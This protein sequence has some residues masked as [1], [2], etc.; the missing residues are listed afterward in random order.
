MQLNLFDTTTSEQ[1]E[2]RSLR[3]ELTEQNYKYY[4]LNAPDL[5]DQEFDAKMHR[6]QELE[7]LHPELF[8]PQSP[9]QQVGSD[10]QKSNGFKQ[11]P[12]RYPMLS[13]ANTYSEEDIRAWYTR[14]CKD[15]GKAPQIVAE[16]KY[17]GLSIS[18]WYENGELTHAVTR[19]DGIRGDDVLQNVKTISTIPWHIESTDIPAHFEVRGEILLPWQ[20]FERINKEREEQ[21]EPLFANP[22]N[23]ASGTLKLQ[24]ATTVARRGLDAYLYYLLGEEVTANTHY[25]SLQTM[26]QWGLQISEAI[27]LCN[28]IEDI[29][30]FINYWDTE[31]KNLPVATDGVV[32]KVN[33]L[34]QQKQLGFTAKSPRWAIAYKFQAEKQQTELLSVSYQVGRTGAVTPVANLAPVQLSGTVVKRATL[35]NA[36]FMQ[37]LGLHEHDMV[38]VEKGGEIIPKITAVNIDLRP[39]N[40]QPVCFITNCPECGTP[41]IRYEGET[42]WYCPNETGCPPQMKGK[43]IHFVARKAMN[44]DGLGEETIDLLYEQHLLS[45]IADLYSLSKE[46]IARQERLGEKSAQNIVRSIEASKQVPWSRVLFALGIRFVGETT[47]KKLARRFPSVQLLAEADKES[48]IQTE[49]VGPQIA[50]SIIAW[51]DNE[52]NRTIVERLQNAGVQLTASEEQALQS[53][54]LQGQTIVISGTFVHHSREELKQMVEDNGGKNA[55]SVS[56]KTTFILAGDNMGPQ[57]LEKA[58]KLGIPIRSEEE[59]MQ[60]LNE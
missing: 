53:T 25:D 60:L 59:F 33:D 30:S 8:D 46:D 52:A 12:H 58:R 35:H 37:E 44:I 21:E 56:S 16:L 24:D 22:R 3:K 20:A 9:T 13:L 45:N 47:A 40:S 42:A 14:L 38:W 4:V 6:L 11:I 17:D 36:D 15:L 7:N 48:L 32:L 1:D 34:L 39:A 49:D 2:I 51:F 41:L 27:H 57:K 28:S 43:L 23:A 54:K 26:R 50:E 55:G 29:M 18:L 31:R 5:S 10:L 19:G